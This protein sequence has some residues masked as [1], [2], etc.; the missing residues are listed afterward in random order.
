[1]SLSQCRC[2]QCKTTLGLPTGAAAGSKVKCPK[3]A[4]VFPIGVEPKPVQQAVTPRRAEPAPAK[5]PAPAPAK[6]QAPAPKKAHDDRP[7]PAPRRHPED[8]G[9]PHPSGKTTK[10]AHGGPNPALVWGLAGGGAVLLVAVVVLI[11]VLT[12]GGNP[13][14]KVVWVQP[15]EAIL[16]GPPDGFPDEPPDGLPP[17][18]GNPPNPLPPGPGEWKPPAGQPKPQPRPPDAEK[19]LDIPEHLIPVIHLPPEKNR[20]RLVLDASGHSSSVQKVLFT[21]NGQQIVSVSTDKT[22]RVWDVA[23]GEPLR[24]FRLPIGRGDEGVLYAAALTPDGKRLAVGGVPYGGGA[25]GEMIYV[26][27]ME[28]GKVLRVLRGHKD[29]IVSLAFSR[30]GR[31]LASASI[32]GLAAVWDANSGKTVRVFQGHRD[33]IREVAF[34]PD[35]RFV[36]TCSGDKTARI[37]SMQTGQAIAEVPAVEQ[38]IL[39]VAW[40]P[41]SKLLATGNQA[42]TIRLWDLAGKLRQTYK[43][44]EAEKIQLTSLSFTPDGRELI[45]TGIDLTGRAGVYSVAEGRRRLVFPHHNN[46]VLTGA[47]SPDGKLAV[48]AGGDDHEGFIWRVADGEVLQKLKGAGRSIWGVGWSRDGKTI[49]WGNTNRGDGGVINGPLE[50]TFRVGEL[51]L[52]GAPDPTFVRVPAEAN[53]YSLQ[54]VDFYKIAVNRNGQQVHLFKSPTDRDRIYSATL[55]PGDLAAFGGSYGTIFIVELKDGRVIHQLRGHSGI[56]TGLS[57]SFDGRY[58]LSGSMDQTMCL[59][60]LKLDPRQNQERHELPLMTLFVA[61]RDWIAWTPEG[62]YACSPQGERLMGWQIN[63]G[64]DV[65]ASYYPAVQF[66]QALYRPDVLKLLPKAGGLGK[67]LVMASRDKKQVAAVTVAQVLPPT[68]TITAPAAP[69]V[70]AAEKTTVEVRAV[71]KSNGKHPVTAMRLLVDGRPYQGDREVRTFKDGGLGERQAAWKVE[72]TPGRHSLAVQAESPVSKG[73]SAA[74]EVTRAGGKEELPKLYLLA[75][76]IS[77]YPGK[78]KLEYAAADAQAITR[79]FSEKTS[80][81]FEKVEVKLIT[82]RDATKKS[83][84]EGLAWLGSKMTARDVG[85]IFF[86]GH[87]AQDDFGQFHLVPVDISPQDPEGSLIPGEFVKKAL[88]NMPGKLIAM[89]DACHS[90]ASAVGDFTKN[91]PGT[92]DLVRDLV[93][94][95]YGVVVMSASQGHEYALES[96]STKHGFFTLGLVEGLHGR[97]DY[98]KDRIIHIHEV[99]A[100]AFFRVRQLSG[101]QQNP[102]TGRPPNIRSFPLA[103]L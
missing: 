73:V 45:Y 65:M 61:G 64:P 40:T 94:D 54:R 14:Q 39:S 58:L 101:G 81:V 74:V 68:V 99:D 91:R 57:L 3:C 51:T 87:G 6:V 20:P 90:G 100:Y 25:H 10:K 98:N 21:P 96:P 80:G 46:T 41:D 93:T 26:I 36:A 12:A 8:D 92:D 33:R 72:L 27:G 70:L 43:V 19:E 79:V 2:P 69:E 32:D 95:D 60:S 22:I 29:T 1:M 59:W 56:V 24:V 23:T 67:A 5:A 38:E 28:T 17:D 44:S 85:V 53:G 75:V 76:G 71:A 52:G 7:Q 13:P 11:I 18:K 31:F 84:L 97:A 86:A 102:V 55:L 4:L 77:A 47:V 89:L 66:R 42:A 16:P 37:W 15:K 35:G 62:Y 103:K 50:H 78:M 63:N 9:H 48:T 34:S 83:I 30:D 49:A 82:D 88:M